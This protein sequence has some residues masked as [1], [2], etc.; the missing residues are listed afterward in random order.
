MASVIAVVIALLVLFVLLVIILL[1]AYKKQKLCFKGK[2]NLFHYKKKGVPA[3]TLPS[4]CFAIF[5]S[6]FSVLCV[7][8]VTFWYH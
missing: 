3:S 7:F 5:E 8:G 2:K 4:L 1:Y 6:G